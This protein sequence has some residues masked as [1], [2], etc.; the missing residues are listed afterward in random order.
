[1]KRGLITLSFLFLLILSPQIS[2]LNNSANLLD[3]E[4]YPEIEVLS[5]GSTYNIYYNSTSGKKIMRL[6]PTYI[7]YLDENQEYQ[8]INTT[9]A[10]LNCE[11]DYC[12]RKGIYYVD[13]KE[14]S[15]QQD[16]VKFFY[17]NT[18]IIYTPLELSYVRNGKEVLISNILNIKGEAIENN[19]LY[20][21]IYGEGLDL[22]YEYNRIFLKENLIINKKENLPKTNL[23]DEVY[24]SL[25]FKMDSNYLDNKNK[26]RET[27]FFAT[28]KIKQKNS[29]EK[30]K[31][32]FKWKKSK[33]IKVKGKIILKKEK[34]KF[35]VRLPPAY[36]IDSAGNK[37]EL[38]YE[39]KKKA[40]DII[41]SI[42]TPYDWLMS[43]ERVYPVKIDPT[44]YITNANSHATIT[45]K[46]NAYYTLEDQGT[47]PNVYT[48]SMTIGDTYEYR[49]YI[50]FAN[51]EIENWVN[52]WIED[53]DLIFNVNSKFG[54]DNTMYFYEI[55]EDDSYL[56][57]TT[58]YQMSHLFNEVDSNNRLGTKTN[59]QTGINSL[60][61][62]T[63]YSW[64]ALENAYDNYEDFILTIK[65]KCCDV[66]VVTTKASGSTG[67][68]FLEID[69]CERTSNCDICLNQFNGAPCDCKEE[70]ENNYCKGNYYETYTCSSICAIENQYT[71]D[72]DGCCSGLR[73]NSIIKK[74]EGLCRNGILDEGEECDD[75]NIF[76]GDGCDYN[77]QIEEGWICDNTLMPSFCV[78]GGFCNYPDGSSF[79]PGCDCNNDSDCNYE[80]YCDLGIGADAC[81]PKPICS[82]EINVITQNY[83]GKPLSGLYARLNSE[84]LKT[85]DSDG[86]A[87]FTIK[88]VGCDNLQTIE[89]RCS[90]DK[91]ICRADST[92][93]S[94]ENDLDSII[95]D[96]SI[97]EQE[98]DIF[99]KEDEVQFR[100]ESPYTKIEFPIHSIGITTNAQVK[101]VCEDTV[102]TEPAGLFSGQIT[103]VSFVEDFRKC[104]RVD[105]FV[106]IFENEKD[107]TNNQI[108]NLF[109]TNTLKANLIINTGYSFADEVIKNYLEENVDVVS[110]TE[111]EIEIYIGK[112][113]DRTTLI[114]NN[115]F[116]DNLIKYN[117]LKEGLPYNALIAND[118]SGQKPRL[119]IFGNEIEGTL[120]GIRE[121]IDNKDKYLKQERIKDPVKK[122]LDETNIE[123]ISVFDYM[124]TD[125]NDGFYRRNNQDFAEVANNVLTR[126]TFNLA[127][128]RVLT[129]N[130]KTALRL[131]N[132]NQELSP[133][134]KEFVNKRP[135]VLSRGIW[136][137]LFTWEELGQEIAQGKG[138][139][140]HRDAWLIEI[141]GGPNTECDECPNYN[142]NDLTDYY[143]PALIAGVQA[144]TNQN[145]VDYVGF[146]NG[147]RTALASLEKYQATGKNN[148][149]YYYNGDSWEL[150]DLDTNF[151]KTFI[152]VACPGNFEGSSFLTQ[153]V[154]EN[155]DN[156]KKLENKNIFHPT[157]RDVAMSIV[158]YGIF[159]PENSKISL[160]LWKDYNNAILNSSDSQLG[161]FNVDV[162][163]IIYGIG[164]LNQLGDERDDGVVTAN[165]S[166][167]ILK[168]IN[169]SISKA[170]LEL[171]LRHDNLPDNKKV[172][173][174]I[175]E[176]L[177]ND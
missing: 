24:L 33:K 139:T 64:A 135:V 147:C 27:E 67:E 14:D 51:S 9:I 171:R 45:Q 122:Y 76:S 141:T 97:C 159:L 85:T 134:F 133:K 42:L 73:W 119:Y 8:P 92:T 173:A 148:A 95:F 91:T 46:N 117:G 87:Q 69:Y 107:F 23:K 30:I 94:S 177:N 34:N 123:A 161:N 50:S 113:A 118:L 83:K 37:I 4:S 154:N 78:Q 77:C 153:K 176:V 151:V 22:N 111:S 88:N 155:P 125:E 157:M 93:I 108:K 165:D 138:T 61:L 84:N 143:F 146:S 39:F 7:N 114:K 105:I 52:D 137:N 55:D 168:N 96:C 15:S 131:K 19:F 41:V 25:K 164:G 65:G 48:G 1:M 38:E 130:D 21:N 32:N 82:G 26:I 13:F 150:K 60:D 86:F 121:V 170:G 112:H 144:Y 79:A 72:E 128:K 120:A 47:S 109:L 57:P 145:Q 166:E 3:L 169:A 80:D 132:I 71:P 116:E 81:E 136:S 90:D 175:K 10:S 156:P 53:V 110:S 44:D 62:N 36:A 98:K 54:L 167:E 126:Q 59:P 17:N 74:C 101:I 104:N 100:D 2:S 158:L 40:N 142:F 28:G 160:N 35:A 163:Q 103:Q 174:K 115:W 5:R 49:S 127:I 89:V 29:K 99:I 162:A 149:G 124:H 102:F 43:E 18:S 11:Y 56:N 140:T 152:G 172:K 68:P 63:I 75:A 16:L 31:E 58:Q 66:G 70:C 20:K 12:V 106:E 6:N 129:T